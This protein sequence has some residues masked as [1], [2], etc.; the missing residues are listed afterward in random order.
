MR[1]WSALEHQSGNG[2]RRSEPRPGLESNV[3]GHTR[4]GK[5]Q[6]CGRGRAGIGSSPRLGVWR[7]CSERGIRGPTA[8][9]ASDRFSA[10]RARWFAMLAIAPTMVETKNTEVTLRPLLERDA[11]VIS[12]A[13][14]AIGWNKPVQQ[15]VDYFAEQERGIRQCW[16]ALLEH[17]VAGYVTLH[18]NPPYP[19]IADKGI[20][21]IQD[22]N[23][24]PAYRRQGIASRLLDLAEQSARARSGKVAI[25]V[26]L[27]PGYNAAQRLYVLRGYVPDGLG[28]TY[29]D[30]Y[31]EEG[32]LLRADNELVLHFIKELRSSG[33]A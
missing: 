33:P 3:C 11:P 7:R 8:R 22:L 31:I 4:T 6:P 29:R 20:P 9:G 2:L 27:H 1:R 13:F 28:V 21:E 30:R 19:G 25:G 24:L 18:F 10:K 5:R 15:Y 23:V 16:V 26:G 32:E 17:E 14:A 12:R